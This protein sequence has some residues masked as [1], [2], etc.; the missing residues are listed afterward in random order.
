MTLR[1]PK[2]TVQSTSCGPYITGELCVRVGFLQMFEGY[3]SV[4]HYSFRR[5]RLLA[6]SS[7]GIRSDL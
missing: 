5:L 2:G 7:H 6:N 4:L 1:S 3:V